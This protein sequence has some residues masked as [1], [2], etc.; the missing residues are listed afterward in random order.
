M[1]KIL[2]TV[3]VRNKYINSKFF[4]NKHVVLV[5]PIVYDVPENQTTPIISENQS[6]PITST[7]PPVPD[8][9]D[10]H[11]KLVMPES[12][13]TFQEKMDFIR[14]MRD[15]QSKIDFWGNYCSDNDDH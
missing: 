2:Y 11:T 13:F 6:S 1:R 10:N 5:N 14:K 12:D 9:S 4:S 15:H 7:I 3:T 8:S